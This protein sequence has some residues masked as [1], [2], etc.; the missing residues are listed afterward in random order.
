MAEGKCHL[1]N[2]QARKL[3]LRDGKDLPKHTQRAGDRSEYPDPP[4]NQ[5]STHSITRGLT[6][7]DWGGRKD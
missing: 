3:G 2:L 7:A 4:P 5:A 6:G 1:F